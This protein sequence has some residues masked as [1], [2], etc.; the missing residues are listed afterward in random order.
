[1]SRTLLKLTL[2]GMSKLDECKVEKMLSFHLERIAKDLQAR[3]GDRNKREVSM[4]IFAKPIPEEDG[5]CESASIEIEVKSKIPTHVSKPYQMKIDRA[6]FQFNED[7][8]DEL[9]SQSLFNGKD[10]EE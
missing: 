9:E 7:F 1:M 5:S 6:G 4:V 2:E 8:P 10:D 3:P